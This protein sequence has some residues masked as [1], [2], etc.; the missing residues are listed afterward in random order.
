VK[1][2]L[3]VVLI[4]SGLVVVLA[5]VFIVGARILHPWPPVPDA[6]VQ[7]TPARV[8]RGRYLANHVA[9]CIGCHSQ[10]DYTRYSMPPVPGTE[11]EGGRYFGDDD[12]PGLTYAE[13]ITPARIGN[14]TDGELIRAITGGVAKGN[15]PLHPLMPFYWLKH[16][17]PE[18]VNSTVAYIR[19]LKPIDHAV[20]PTVYYFPLNLI[21]WTIPTAWVATETDGPPAPGPK[22]SPADKVAYGR[23]LSTLAECDMCH[24]PEDTSAHPIPADLFEGGQ[25]MR[26]EASLDHR[27]N[28]VVSANLTPHET[29]LG[30]M[31]QD[32][33]VALFKEYATDDARNRRQAPTDLQTA[34]PWA[35]FSGMTDDDLR[36]I[37][38]YL[39]TLKPICN[40][41]DEVFP[42]AS[43]AP[44]P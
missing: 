19:S 21:L 25:A 20:P 43:P 23:Y 35:E 2:L 5:G 24:G 1:K 7:I 12:E 18:D 17:D 44:A 6:T 27:F 33:F 32:H 39:R 29:G 40:E 13:N 38:Q 26:A 11:G 22:P 15:K 28:W 30:S 10:P 36:A 42:S 4:L 31:T 3:R 9:R 8:A 34:M 16:M 37:Y 14:W 41:V